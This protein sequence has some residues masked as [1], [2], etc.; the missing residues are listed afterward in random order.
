MRNF[1]RHYFQQ[2]SRRHHLSL[3]QCFEMANDEIYTRSHGFLQ[4]R[5]YVFF[6]TN[7]R[8]QRLSDLLD[9]LAGINNFSYVGSGDNAVVVQYNDDQVLRLRAPAIPNQVNTHAVPAAPMIC[10]VW[11]EVIFEEARLNFVPFIDSLSK[12]M[13]QGKVSRP[14]AEK[15]VHA[16]MKGCL[17]NDPKLWFYDYKNFDFKFEQIGILPSGAPIVLDLGSVIYTTDATSA[18]QEKLSRD[19]EFVAALN[20]GFDDWDGSWMDLSGR[21]HIEALRRPPPEIMQLPADLL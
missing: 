17:S 9:S 8:L 3:E 6:R 21:P 11:K 2:R 1:I 19:M 10:P 18:E 7:N 4:N 16:L 5:A 20:V 13:S 15:Y 14:I 12:R